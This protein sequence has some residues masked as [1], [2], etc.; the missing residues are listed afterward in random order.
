M[1][2]TAP[3]P[4]LRR[5]LTAG[6]LILLA[7][8]VA[9]P[10]AA[11]SPAAAIGEST[12]T[13]PLEPDTADPTIEFHDGNYYL[14]ATTWDNRVVMRKAPTLAALGTAT[15]VTVYSDTNPGRN[16]NMWAP[17]LQRLEG[18]NGWRWYL[19]YTMG[20][21]GNFDRQ[22]LQVIE[23]AGDDPM[24]PYSY[25]GRPIPTDDWN[26]DG[27][28]LELNGELFVTWSAF[29]AGP[30]R[31]QNNYIARM[32]D[33]WTV[34]GPQNVL[35]Q[36]LEPWET[37]GAPV[38]EGPVP[39]QKDGRTWI[40]YSASFC[41]TEDYQLGTLEYDGTGDPVLA[42]SWTKSDGPVFSKAN[43]EYGT[44]HN[45]FFDSPDGTETWNLYHAN[46]GPNDGCS[47][48]RSARAHL[49]DWTE[50]GEPD[51]GVPLGTAARIPVPSG[52]NAPITAR[53]EGAPWQL[54][55]RSTGLCATVSS[56]QS[57]DGAGVVQAPCS[58]P[59][60]SWTLDSTGDG[61]LRIVNASSGKSL[62]PVGCATASGA[63]LQQS[64]WLT[65]S[66]QQWTV[67]PGT[68]GYSTLTNRTSGKALDAVSGAIRQSTPSAAASQEW[69]LRP[70]GAVA[71][72]SLVTGKSFDLPNCSTADGALLQQQEWLGS[73]CQRVTFTAA[74]DGAVE[75]HPVSASAK[76]VTVTGG[77][78]ADGATVT[79]GAC[80]VTGSSWRL[81][82]GNDGT[83]ELRAVHS[84][85]AL[86][87]SNCSDQNGTRIGQWSVLNN[88]CQ[89]FRVSLGAPAAP[90]ALQLA[91][92]SSV[93]CVAGKPV[94]TTT[95]KNTDDL[96]A[97]ITVTTA[98]GT[99]TFPAVAGGKNATA[100]FTV[101]QPTLAAGSAAVTGAGV[102]DAGR[103]ATQSAAYPAI[104]C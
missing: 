78:T 63:A 14:V 28:Y 8:I 24:G 80:G 18:P 25:K 21:A 85:K 72:T 3:A 75:L 73:P 4:G 90:V 97:D 35:S 103:A 5:R 36:P 32:S 1:H 45:D 12:F 59:R 91:A 93:R 60:A 53:V 22:H 20:T 27:A 101:R 62:G 48:Q 74:A 87:L 41:G 26:I 19:M 34:S 56:A 89:R 2:L 61:F 98:S 64:A 71:V 57:G 102:D 94:L 95:V 70:A 13:N 99:K 83:V 30:N 44:G 16:A 46:P 100:S 54:V 42:S 49:V 23:S 65:T 38:N 33:P 11:A 43:G 79:Q 76:C 31:L 47:R 52:E 96:P 58:T 84:G 77:S 17:E 92:T 55:S 9:L 15:P 6:L 88:D 86:D 66:C 37:I 40:V 50:G 7:A 81:R 69:A 51:F 39:L 68:G 67:A 29:S 82:P 10:L 104:T